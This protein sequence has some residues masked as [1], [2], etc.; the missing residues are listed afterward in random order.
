MRL[1]SDDFM[2][3]VRVAS[4]YGSFKN[5][6]WAGGR[7][8]IGQM[9]SPIDMSEAIHKINDAGIAVRYTYTNS[10]IEEKHLSDTF[11]NLTMKMADNGK[12]EVLVNSPVLEQYLRKQYPSFKFIQSITACEHDINKINESTEKY[13]LVVIDFHDNHNES[14]LAKIS[15][16]EKI[17]ILVNGYCPMSCVRSKDHYELISKINCHQ[18]NIKED[19]CLMSNRKPFKGFYDNLENNKMTTL[20]FDDVYKKYYNNHRL[21]NIKNLCINLKDNLS[22]KIFNYYIYKY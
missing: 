16:K 22:Q 21:N 14:F 5:A 20:T 15:N 19:L 10:V 8:I 13:D 6:I 11:C 3:N 7:S 12:N 9:P 1:H 4:F 18:A 2:D 17:E